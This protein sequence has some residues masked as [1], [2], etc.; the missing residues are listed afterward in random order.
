MTIRKLLSMTMKFQPVA[1]AIALCLCAAAKAPAQ[2]TDPPPDS[3]RPE[4]ASLSPVDGNA[5][6]EK[7]YRRFN[8][9]YRLGPTD[10]ISIR[11]KGQRDYSTERTRVSPAG[12]IYH[13][14]L[15]EVSVVGLTINQVTERLTND[16]SEYL[17]NPEVSVQLIEA[18][19]AKIGVIGEVVRP[20]IIVMSR[21]MTLLDVISESGGFADT[22]SKTSVEVL[23]QQANG[24]RAPLRINVK[25]IL[26]GRAK[27]EDNIQ[28]RA[29]DLV[30]VH[31][32]KKKTLATIGSIVNIASFAA[33]L[34]R[35][36]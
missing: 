34:G 15:G 16:L 8:E 28:M 26:N 24:S 25:D 12:T 32:N 23:R 36:W 17:K 10:E 5:Y 9:T 35:G 7:I 29:G 33:F 11:I 22:G 14:L 2:T 18:T 21:P 6:F 1:A 31:G 27:P 20:G 13:E 3:P 19:S 4:A 30:I